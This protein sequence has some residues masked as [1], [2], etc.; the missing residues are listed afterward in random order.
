MW[1]GGE[2]CAC[3]LPSE[4]TEASEGQEVSKA[5]ILTSHFDFFVVVFHLTLTE[6]LILFIIL[7]RR[8]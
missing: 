1:C 7:G 5:N 8:L 6:I 4:V 3:A 2:L